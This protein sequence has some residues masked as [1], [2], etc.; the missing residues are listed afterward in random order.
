[1]F[2]LTLPFGNPWVRGDDV[3]YYAFAWPM[4]I[5]YRLAFTKDW[6]ET[7]PSFRMGRIGADGQISPNQYTVTGHPDATPEPMT[8]RRPTEIFNRVSA[9]S[10][11][12]GIVAPAPVE[13]PQAEALG[14]RIFR[15][16]AT[17]I[18]GQGLNFALSGAATIILARY[19]GSEGL[20]VFGALYAYLG[21]YG[22]LA[23][24]G[25]ESILAR[26]VAQDRARAG[27]ILLTGVCISALF[28]IGSTAIALAAASHFGYGGALRPLMAFAA[29]DIL[30]LAPI[31]L[32]GIVF[33]VDLRQWYGVGIALVRQFAWL[34]ALVVVAAA[35][36]GLF[37]VILVRTFCALLEVAL[38]FLAIHRKGFLARP[39]RLLSTEAKKYLAYGFP[40]AVS[41]LAVGVYHRIDQ[42]MLHKMVNDQVLGNYVAAVRLTELINLFPIAVMASLFPILSQTAGE[43]DR[44]HRYLRLS[45]RSLMAI[46]FGVCVIATLFSGP[47]VHLLYGVKFAAAASLLAVLI[48]SEVPVFFGVVIS[49]GLVA[50]NLQN[51]MPLSTGI[52][53]AV[54]V[55]LNLYMIPRWGALGSAWATNISY[56]LAAIFLYLVFRATRPLAW[57]GFRILAPPCLLALFITAVL[58]MIPLPGFLS[59]PAALGLC[60]LGAWLLGIVRKSDL[61]QLAQLIGNSLGFSKTHAT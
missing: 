6:W 16:I 27:S 35:R 23:T 7:N 36:G 39:W 55:A 37:W 57:L 8:E 2:V 48:W 52:G 60:G 28:A 54:N 44:F 18:G 21:L 19:L 4:F 61:E 3:G 43:H 49:N 25:L 34:L 22:W 29:I 12:S 9:A 24:F 59:F 1:L 56:T 15:N 31:R 40:V 53:A 14:S 20:G 33:Q 45:F 38:I 5:E 41:T 47:I 30:L 42:V 58:K 10:I 17:L 32:P 50:K 13:S 51:Y 46:A 26:Q 11:K